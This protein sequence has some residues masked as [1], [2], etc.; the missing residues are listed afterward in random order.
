MSVI[1]TKT[2][3]LVLVGIL[4]I[5]MVAPQPA[6]AQ[7]GLLSGITGILN[8]LNGATAALQNFINNVMR[9]ILEAVRTASAAIQNILTTL[10]NFYEQIVWPIAEIN[11]IR[12]LVQQ[13]IAQFSGILN[14]LYNLNV[15]SAQLPNPRQLETI[16]RNRKPGDLAT[17]RTAFVQTYGAVPAATDAHPEERDL[18]DVDDAMAIDHLMM[19]KMADAGADQTVAAASAIASHGLIVAPGTAAYSTAA[20]HIATLQSNAHIQKMIA[21]ALRQEAAR[22][23]HSTMST[24]RSAAFTRESRSKATEMNR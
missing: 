18:M 14:G 16:I 8:G 20:A 6:Y 9:P 22:L 1:L 10:R 7:G 3:V 19:L 12:G 13:L 24:K 11:R 23:G 21:S 17:L 5:A 15:S 2:L 4:M